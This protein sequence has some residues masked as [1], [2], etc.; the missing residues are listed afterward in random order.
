MVCGC[1]CFL[2][3]LVVFGFSVE[4]WMMSFLKWIFGG[5]GGGYGSGYGYGGDGGYGGGY[6]GGLC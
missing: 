4:E 5:Y 2:G 1:C 3:C 6:Y